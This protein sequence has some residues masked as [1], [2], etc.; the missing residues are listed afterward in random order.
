MS[1][2]S[3]RTIMMSRPLTTSGLSVDASA[4]SGKTVAGRRFAKK[5]HSLR[6]PRMAASGRNG[7]SSASYCGPPTAPKRTASACLA[8]SSVFPGRGCLCASYAAPPTSAS[9]VS[10]VRPSL[11]KTSST[12]FACS[13]ISGPMPSPARRAI[14]TGPPC[15]P[16]RRCCADDP[17]SNHWAP[18]YAGATRDWAPAYAGATRDWAP[19]GAGATRDWAPAG[20]GATRDW[21]PAG[22]GATRRSRENP[23]LALLAA[24]LVGLDLVGMPQRE[25]DLVQ[26]FDQVVLAGGLHVEMEG[27]PGA[28]AHRLRGQVDREPEAGM[29]RDLVKEVVDFRLGQHDRQ[30]AVLEAVGEEDVRVRRRDDRLEAVLLQRP[31]GV[32]ARGAA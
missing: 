14:F 6:S 22:A 23:R 16:G 9:S 17:G 21:A 11:R 10:M 32:L 2:V 4:S 25:A 7:R 29:R 15:H 19:A 12:A 20:A 24:L 18:A 26:P 8:R 13:R 5:S 31:R 28:G 30:Q 27:L 3:S 1:P